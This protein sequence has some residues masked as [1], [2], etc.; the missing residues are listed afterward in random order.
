MNKRILLL[1]IPNIITNITVPLLG[2]IDTAIVGHLNSAGS[3]LDYIGGVAVG[4]MI[5]TFIY[6]NFGFLRM[7]TSGFTAQ[8]FGAKDMQESVNILSRACF[9]AFTAA[10]TLI[11]LQIPIS[12]IAEKVIENKNSVLD[13]ALTYFFIRIWAAPATLG[14]YALKGWF[15]GMQDSKTPMWIAIFI[16]ILNIVFSLWFVLGLNMRIEG[17][18]WG[19]VIAQYGGLVTTFIFLFLKYKNI[20]P[21]FNFRSSLNRSKMKEFFKVNSDI[22]LRTL[23][24]II[25]S[26]Y[27]TIASSKMPYPLLAVNTLLMQLFTL[28]SYFMDGFA[29]A[30][31]SL[32]GRYVGAKDK[33]N[34]Q[35]SVKYILLW[36][37]IL[38]LLVM[39][40]YSFCGENILQILTN[41]QNVIA[42]AKDY[43]I[44]TLLIPLCGFV[45]FLYDGILIG[46]TK[47]AIMR[48]AIFI[49]TAFYFLLFFLFRNSIGNNALW[50]GFLSYLLAR[51][52]FMAWFSWKSIFGKKIYN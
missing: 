50:I 23:C 1:A 39:I 3:S 30:A 26:T 7:G 28:F 5:F 42:T 29:Y 45:A 16:N 44:W 32:C 31:E 21:L 10:I 35:K 25:V 48:N 8:A 46:M 41:Q 11:L 43:L 14:M 24:L 51:S 12:W 20:L 2:M 22:F 47:S 37:L 6:W 13:L 4:S 15:I 19:T 52:V 17:V 49:A 34:L 18:A 40:I 38:S 36:G 27:F 9:I 33:S